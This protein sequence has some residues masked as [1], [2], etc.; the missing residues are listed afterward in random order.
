MDEENKQIWICR[1]G[2][3]SVPQEEVKENDEQHED[4]EPEQISLW[5]AA[6]NIIIK[7]IPS[8]TMLMAINGIAM[9]N[10]Y[11]VGYRGDEKMAAAVEL[12][13]ITINILIIAIDFGIIDGMTVLVSRA[14]GR[15]DY[16]TWEDYLNIW[17]YVLLILAFPQFLSLLFLDHVYGALKQPSEIAHSAWIFCIITFPGWILMNL[18]EWNRRYLV[19]CEVCSSGT[20]INI[21]TFLL[22]MII[23]NILIFQFKIGIYGAG[24]ATLFVYTLDFFLLEIFTLFQDEEVHKSRWRLPDFQMISNFKELLNYYILCSLITVLCWWPIQVNTIFAG[25]LGKAQLATNK[26]LNKIFF[27]WTDFSLGIGYASI[28]VIGNSLG[29]N[30]SMKAKV[31]KNTS[32][33]IGGIV[34]LTI[35]VTLFANKDLIML[36]YTKTTE[37]AIQ[38]DAIFIVF[39][40]DLFA[41]ISYKITQEILFAAGQ[42]FLLLCSVVLFSWIIMLPSSSIFGFNPVFGYTGLKIA[43]AVCNVLLTLN[44]ILIIWKTNWTK[45]ASE[46]SLKDIDN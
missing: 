11:L 34:S 2:Y 39:L 24:I 29:E 12:G 1:G 19:C 10:A 40:I 45:V 33:I 44:S 30:N 41:W 37:E 38:I 5:Q 14:Y 23:L 26:I 7:A 18:Y 31:Y 25:M 13:T 16:E 46:A 8:I 15:K 43:F 3:R 6:G 22:H 20:A 4:E 27:L 9:M 42:Q 36:S 35:I 17:R 28:A 21:A 32:L